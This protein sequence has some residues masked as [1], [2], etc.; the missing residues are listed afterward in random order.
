MLMS[1]YVRTYVAESVNSLVRIYAV[2]KG[3]HGP[4]TLQSVVILLRTYVVRVYMLI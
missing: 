3:L 4:N 2:D 1:M